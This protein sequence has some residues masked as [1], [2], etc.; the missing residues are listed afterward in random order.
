MWGIYNI[1]YAVYTHV[2]YDCLRQYF[3]I[4]SLWWT[5]SIPSFPQHLKEMT[6]WPCIFQGWFLCHHFP[7]PIILHEAW[8]GNFPWQPGNWTVSF[9]SGRTSR[10]RP[11]VPTLTM[12][13]SRS[14]IKSKGLQITLNDEPVPAILLPMKQ[15][16][17]TF[18]HT[19]HIQ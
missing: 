11:L 14:Y 7:L 1:M 15:F 16:I 2:K 12:Q 17:F 13:W 4:T 5:P 8:E 18:T 19:G 6:P 10:K 3:L 9:P